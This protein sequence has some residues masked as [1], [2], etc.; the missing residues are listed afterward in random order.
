MSLSS[1]GIGSGLNVSDIVSKLMAVESQP[2]TLLNNK[3]ASYQA[4]LSAYG[5]VSGALSSFQNALSALSDPAK[6]QGLIASSGDSTILTS[7]AASTAVAGSYNINI[8]QL[9]QAQSQMTTGQASVSTPIGGGASTAVTFQFGTVIANISGATLGASVASSGIAAGSLI[10]NGTTIATSSSTTSA[11]ALAAQINLLQSTTGVTATANTT[12]TGA[13][14]YSAV[15]TGA[16]DAYSLVVGGTTIAGI[17]AN[18]SLSAAQ[19]DSAIGTASAQLAANGITYT[20]TAAAG[21][22]HFTKTDGS[23]LSITQT[24]SGSASGGIAGLA[25]G[26][27]TNYLSSVSLSSSNPIV[28]AGSS[29]ASAGL[30]AGTT[31]SG[32]VQDATQT[33]GSVTIDSTN[34]SLQGIRDAIN[35]ANLGVTATIIGDGSANPNHLVLTSNKTGATSNIKIAVTGDSAISDLLAYGNM[36]QTVAAQNATLNVNGIAISSATNTITGAIQ[37][38]TVNASK[39]GSTTLSITRDTA[40]VQ[41]AINS[42]VT[43]YNAA[44]KTLTSLTAYD[45]KTKTGGPL[46]GDSVVRTIQSQMAALLTS[47]IQGAS[48]SLTTLNQVGISFQKDGTLALDSTKL[49]TAITNNFGDIASL[50]SANGTTTDSLVS[51]V[52]S[53]SA[54]KAGQY[55]VNVTSLATQGALV[56]NAPPGL[57]ITQ[58]SNDQLSFTI[59]GVTASV[60]LV[61]GTYTA[62]A[63]AAQVQSAINGASAL[64]SAGSSVTVGLNASNQLTITSNR[65]GSASN[66]T[67]VGNAANNLLGATPAATVG[68]DVVGTINGNAATGS[69]Q[70]LTGAIGSPTEGLKLQISGGNVG[71][72]GTANFAQ[73]YA[74]Q[75]NNQINSYLGTSGLISGRT[76]GINASVASIEKQRTDMTAQLADTQK[77]L[78]AQYSALD[79]TIASMQSTQSFLTQQ[80]AQLAA[81][82]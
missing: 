5:N 63:L 76:N 57:T 16:G 43:A 31:Q 25:S 60:N 9:A 42:L 53:S 24:L 58:G 14:A 33:A 80:L 27:P 38:V 19:L 40:S 78:L 41:T 82:R 13:L 10:L 51:F 52:S 18:S 72:R 21:N 54:T 29:P 20:G 6:F 62:S 39:V 69:G 59:D 46:I 44:N 11:K 1:P 79:T 75:L 66:V 22:L 56:G 77:R 15:T 68:T 7:T 36:T 47:P 81:L 64:S 55:A 70:F 32:F 73:G 35:K 3:E 26:V 17:G 50:F 8:T 45:P 37:G 30:T 49:Q 67:I 4:T 34:N 74:Y 71:A 23:N 48:G 12:D 65:Y 28:V 61:A 2:L